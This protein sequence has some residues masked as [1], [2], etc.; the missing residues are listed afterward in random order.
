M[1]S[2]STLYFHVYVNS[3]FLPILLE[4]P[5]IMY[6]NDIFATFI[7]SIVCTQDIYTYYKYIAICS[8][9]H[10]I[11]NQQVDDVSPLIILQAIMPVTYHHFFKLMFVIIYYT[12]VTAN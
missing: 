2:H 5:Y 4:W 3:S 7:Y 9:T 1:S 10:M 6:V 11:L 8:D 12:S